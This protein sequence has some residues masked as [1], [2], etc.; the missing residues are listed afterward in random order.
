MPDAIQTLCPACFHD[1]LENGRCAVCGYV[2]TEL[3]PGETGLP[4]F[5]ILHGKYLLGRK[6]GQGGF[7]ITYCAR[8]QQTG[9]LCCVKE[10]YPACRGCAATS[11]WWI[12]W[13][14]S[15]RRAPPTS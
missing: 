11:P 3:Q 4:P 15:R 5:T 7:G 12:S 2:E 1:T 9:A 13:I 14:T 6:L 8:D 10:Y